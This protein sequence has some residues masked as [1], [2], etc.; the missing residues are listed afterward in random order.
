MLQCNRPIRI[1][2]RLKKESDLPQNEGKEEEG[3]CE[4]S[5]TTSLRH[6]KIFQLDIYKRLI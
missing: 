3:G 5:Y 6:R 1:R 4:M 2:G